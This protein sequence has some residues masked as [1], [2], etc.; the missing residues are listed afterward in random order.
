VAADR[1]LREIELFRAISA[2][3]TLRNEESSTSA[4]RA[5]AADDVHLRTDPTK[6]QIDR[7]ARVDLRSKKVIEIPPQ[8][9][10]QRNAA[11]S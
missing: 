9:A 8:G 3:L 7:Y 5:V 1:R 6:P 2:H 11:A 4:G 10:D